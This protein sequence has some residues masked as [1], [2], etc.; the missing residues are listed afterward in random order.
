[1][2][3]ST[4]WR[5]WVLAPRTSS[6]AEGGRTDGLR[7]GPIVQVAAGDRA[8][9]TQPLDAALEAD[10]ASRGAGAGTE[11]DDVV[12]DRDRL[13]LVLDDEHGVALV[14]QLQQQ[15]VHPLDVMRVQ[16]DASARRRRR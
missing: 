4:S 7:R 11:V 2:S 5:L 12:G 15:P 13:R 14:A 8:A 9:A 1:M 3:T 16:A 10:L 6:I